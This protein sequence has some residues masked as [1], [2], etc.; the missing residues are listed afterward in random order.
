MQELLGFKPEVI[1]QLAAEAG[2]DPATLDLL[3]KHDITAK[4]LLELL[5]QSGLAATPPTGSIP[6]PKEVD[7][8]PE[9]D[10]DTEPSE[11]VSRNS[12]PTNDQ[13]ESGSDG[14]SSGKTA[15]S[16]NIEKPK[17]HHPRN[18]EF[19]TYLYTRPDDFD[20]DEAD[21]DAEQRINRGRQGV[22]AVLK[23]E[24]DAGRFPEAMPQTHEGCDVISKDANG[25][26]ERYIE[27]KTT[28]ASWKNRG[29]TLSSPQFKSAQANESS[30]WLYVVEDVGTPNQK[31]YRIQ[32]P[33]HR[34]KHFVF[35]HGWRALTEAD[36]KES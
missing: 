20:E 15:G 29:V 19:I 14:D 3:K 5:Q 16:S 21:T 10:S 24:R 17:I 6:K 4:K 22:E 25:Y 13:T 8:Q 2:I 12:H 27:V 36:Q 35:N 26:I 18:D 33:A 28:G 1:Q 30:F 34:T 7:E 11:P 9:V 31:I 23:F 32:N